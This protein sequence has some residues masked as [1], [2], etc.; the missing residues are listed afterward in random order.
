MKK[1]AILAALIMVVITGETVAG[2]NY[3][4]GNVE[5]YTTIQGGL[6]IMVDTGVPDNCAV[7]Y[8]GG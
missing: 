2:P 5:N 4:I 7:L 1:I 8:M 3:I 6:M